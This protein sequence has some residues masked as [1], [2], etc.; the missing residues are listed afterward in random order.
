M[1]TQYYQ[2]YL[3][4]MSILAIHWFADFVLQ[5]RW[6]AENKSKNNEAL[7]QHVAT[8]S[9]A[10]I[11]LLFVL[12]FLGVNFT[13]TGILV[14]VSV[15]GM[16]HFMTDYVTSRCTSYFWQQKNVHS[17]FAVIG[18]DQFIHNATLLGTVFLLN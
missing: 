18:I 17:F 1:N 16:F 7:S 9:A 3:L 11:C 15:N 10:F 2:F 5:T 8:Y 13:P 4:T 14:Y 6:Q 12:Y